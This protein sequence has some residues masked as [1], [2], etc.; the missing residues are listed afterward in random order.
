MLQ[1]QGIAFA[2]SNHKQLQWERENTRSRGPATG[3]VTATEQGKGER[4]QK[5]LTP[6]VN[7][8]YVTC[9]MGP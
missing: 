6:D 8:G 5:K 7:G 3:R 9:M 4:G 1:D 2:H